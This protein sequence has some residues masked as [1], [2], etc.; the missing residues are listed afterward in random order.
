MEDNVLG[1]AALVVKSKVALAVLGVLVAGGGGTT[2]A[3]AATGHLPTLPTAQNSSHASDNQ[4]NGDNHGH[5]VGLEGT[6]KAYD[7]GAH[8]VSVLGQNA[9]SATTITVNDQT[10][11]NGDQATTLSDLATNIG[12]KVQVQSTKQSDGSLI[13]WKI[14]VE[15]AQDTQSQGSI[16]RR[17]F[18][19]TVSS[20]T[21]NG[22]VIKTATG[23]LVTIVTQSRTSFAGGASSTVKVGMRVEVQG[24]VQSDGSVLADSVRIESAAPASGN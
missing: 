23:D 9:T 5:T 8:T 24:A 7:A 4:G 22:F 15:G 16:S 18:V 6:L 2:V 13:A 10:Q 21:T 14:T 20:V 17:E 3:L 1:K 11:V 12:H 19:G